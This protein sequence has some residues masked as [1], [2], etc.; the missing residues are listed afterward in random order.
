L[1]KNEYRSKKLLVTIIVGL[2]VFF[3]FIG[4][5]SAADEA[6]SWRPT[7]D[8]IMMWVNFTI[9]AAVLYKFLKN[10]LMD[11]I[12]GQKYETEKEIQ[13]AED[14]KKKAEEKIQEAK[15]MLEEGKDRFNLIKER[16]I[17][18]GE[19]KKEQLI[20]EAEQQ[21]SY[22][23]IES[24]RKVDN[25]IYRAQEKF[26]AELVDT[27]FDLV[28]ERLPKEITEKDG[29]KLVNNYIENITPNRT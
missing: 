12:Q 28:L 29:E 3:I 19:K 11:F 6:A 1:I 5:V 2:A 23:L 9:L 13:R 24:K 21:S 8:I 15:Q 7:Y 10:P 17:T 18:Q 4:P 22:M 16:I 20:E 27:A 14:L 26:R 25:Q